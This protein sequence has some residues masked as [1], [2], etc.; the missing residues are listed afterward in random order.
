MSHSPV[1][2]PNLV[3]GSTESAAQR[4]RPEA[5]RRPWVTPQ[6]ATHESMTVLT[7]HFFGPAGVAFALQ[8]N[9]GV[10]GQKFGC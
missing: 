7:K 6:L 4:A 1:D 2:R 8:I 9:C 10:S 5:A 3:P